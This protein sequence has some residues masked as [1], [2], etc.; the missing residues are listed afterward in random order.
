MTDQVPDCDIFDAQELPD[1]C[2]NQDSCIKLEKEGC[3]LSLMKRKVITFTLV[4]KSHFVIQMCNI[5]CN[6]NF[7]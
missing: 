4:N 2:P 3:Y 7:D 1:L 5:I 6:S